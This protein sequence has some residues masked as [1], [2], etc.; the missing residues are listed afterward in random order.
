MVPELPTMPACR[1]RS[2]SLLLSIQLSAL[3]CASVLQVGAVE[4]QSTIDDGFGD[5]VLVPG[6]DFQMGDNFNEGDSDEVPVHT[7]RVESFYIGKHKI[8]NAAYAKFIEADGYS[9]ASYWSAGGFGNYGSRPRHWGDATCA[10]GGLDCNEGFPV[11]GVSWFEAMAYCEWLSTQT[12]E[13]YR[14]PTEA[15]WE[16]AARGSDQRRF[17]WGA[18][19][20]GPHANYEFSGDPFEPGITPVGFYDGTAR[21]GFQT[22]DNASPYG[23]YDMIGSV[24]EWCLDWYDGA[25]Y[26][27]SSVIDPRGPA[28]GSSRILRAG[29]W[30]DSA[31]YQRAA[32][33]NSSFPENR[34]PIQGF[35]AVR[36]R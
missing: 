33:R 1:L 5:Y 36:E 14:L 10:G 27:G 16:R 35:R 23:A 19:I 8:T 24:W 28:T 25:Y 9:E 22:Q 21:Q 32:N 13:T 11:V 15:E 2:S 34:N 31:Y 17:A 12:G 7:V 30:V 18:D 29:G 26:S 3:I 6:G 4:A 20:D